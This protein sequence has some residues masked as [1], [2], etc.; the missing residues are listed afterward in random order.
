MKMVI[1]GSFQ[2][3]TRYAERTFGIGP[4]EWIDGENCAA[5]DVFTCRGIRRFHEY[6]RR[7]L[8]E[9]EDL[10]SLAQELCGKNPDIVIVTDE[11]GYGVVPAEPFDRM[12]RE[13]DSRIC[14]ELAA[15]SDEVHR[16][17][18]GIGIVLKGTDRPAAD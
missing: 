14:T 15:F 5:E 17:V 6:V 16:V 12:Y 3:K 13:T 1:G 11:L 7:R 10:S 2:G 8:L 4:D 9:K 18:C